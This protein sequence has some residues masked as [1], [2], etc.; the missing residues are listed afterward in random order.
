M[1]LKTLLKIV[2]TIWLWLEIGQF[3]EQRGHF[4]GDVFFW[5]FWFCFVLVLILGFY[6]LDIKRL[7]EERKQAGNRRRK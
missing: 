2:G 6:I 5:P 4:W 3:I 7:T 1:Y